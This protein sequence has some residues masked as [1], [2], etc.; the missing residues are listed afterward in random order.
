LRTD[1]FNARKILFLS[2]QDGPSEQVLKG[3][4]TGYLSC[5]PAVELAYL[6]K[7]S[8]GE[9]SGQHVALCLVGGTNDAPQIVQSAETMFQELFRSTEK[10]EVLFLTDEQRIRVSAIAEP[11]YKADE[12]CRCE[13]N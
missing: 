10:L 5:V 8:H 2:E 6:V 3:C 9:S 4:L 12:S 13:P 11:F 7:V 1:Q